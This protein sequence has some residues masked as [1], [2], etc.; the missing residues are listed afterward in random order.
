M[1]V[2]ELLRRESD[3]REFAAGETIFVEGDPGDCM[4]AVLDGEVTVSK[5]GR[6]WSA[7]GREASSARW[8]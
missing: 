3:V 5:G 6:T 1:P 4:Y 7:S 8:R 2:F